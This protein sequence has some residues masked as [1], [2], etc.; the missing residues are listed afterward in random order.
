MINIKD[1]QIEEIE[2]EDIRSEYVLYSSS[3]ED[4]FYQMAED[5]AFYLGNQLTEAQKEYLVSVGQPPES[6]NKIR[7]AVEQVLSNV[8][9]TT[10]EWDIE[11]IGKLDNELAQI[12]NTLFDKVW[13]DSHGD[14]HF[15]NCAKSFII[16]GIA[17]M[18][19]Y[20]D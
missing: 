3:G 12:Y 18:Y 9:A 5:E 2:G 1:L 20:P 10:P 11:P 8:S 17:Y 16:K 7:P 4:F 13:H 6:N 19:V 15:R 14:V